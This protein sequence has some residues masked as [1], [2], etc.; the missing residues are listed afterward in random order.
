M[1]DFTLWSWTAKCW[2]TFC[3]DK[4][5]TLLLKSSEL[6]PETGDRNSKRE[7]KK[8]GETS[9]TCVMKLS[10]PRTAAL[11]KPAKGVEERVCEM[12]RKGKGKK[13]MELRGRQ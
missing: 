2:H 7:K 6:W 3:Q 9:T 4:V 13:E 5:N 8:E 12:Q 11:V 10:A 1:T